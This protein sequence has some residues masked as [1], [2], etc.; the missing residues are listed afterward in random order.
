MPV[1]TRFTAD[2]EFCK[3]LA[4]RQDVDLIRVSLELAR[5]AQPN[6]N[7]DHTLEWI[8]RRS[9]ELRSHIT[10]LRSDRDVLN[11][12]VRCLAGTHGLHGDKDAYLRAESSY[13]NRVIETG[14]GIPISL[15]MV[16]V[17]VAQ[18]AGIELNG[19]AAPMHFLTRI[20]TIQG[21]FFINA[22]HAGEVLNYDDCIEW[23]ESLSGLSSEEIERSLEPARP[24][25]VVIRMLNNLKALHVT[26]ECWE[27]A[28]RVQCRLLALHNEAFD[29]RRDL[30]LIAIK[31][32]RP[33]VAVDLLQKC[34]KDCLNKD[35]PML[36][37]QL[38]TAEHN[39]SKWN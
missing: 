22:F 11:E 10:R 35:R 36:L 33:G 9:S 23:I 15:S 16:Y 29:Q 1:D 25:E 19:V 32:N 28:W 30:A 37:Q 6:L 14:V 5:D 17:A 39:L 3:L 20:D 26:Q 13:I 18:G 7:F 31:A 34:L 12:L 38:R 21:P 2:H 4:R 24:R 8:N 27:Q